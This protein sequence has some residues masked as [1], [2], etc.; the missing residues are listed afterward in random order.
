MS[1]TRAVPAAVPSVFHSSRPLLLSRAAKKIVSPTST[2]WP[3]DDPSV[4][5]LTFLSKRGVPEGSTRFSR[6]SRHKVRCSLLFLA[7]SLCPA[8]FLARGKRACCFMVAPQLRRSAKGL[9]SFP[10]Y[11]VAAVHSFL[12]GLMPYFP[13]GRRRVSNPAG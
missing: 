11:L 7:A 6:T 10:R 9:L 8:W 5:G 4:P 13:R 1:L 3:G 2:I 12:A